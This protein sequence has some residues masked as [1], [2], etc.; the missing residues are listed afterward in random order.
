[1][2]MLRRNLLMLVFLICTVVVADAQVARWAPNLKPEFDRITVNNVGL[3]EVEKNKK[4]GLYSRDW[5]EIVPIEYDSIRPFREG[6]AAMYKAGHFVA[7]T[8]TIGNIIDVSNY[9]YS[10]VEGAEDFSCGALL[11]KRY[12]QS[13][14]WLYHYI[15]YDGRSITPDQYLI[16]A[17]P[18][19]NGYAVVSRYVEGNTTRYYDIIDTNGRS[20]FAGNDNMN[21]VD[22]QFASTFVDGEAIV[23]YK[24]RVHKITTE[25]LVPDQI[26]VYS[27]EGKKN[28]YKV[29]ISDFE[30]SRQYLI[31]GRIHIAAKNGDFMFDKFRRLEEYRL[32]DA[33]AVTMPVPQPQTPVEDKSVFEVTSEGGLDGLNYMGE[34]LLPPQFDKVTYV[35]NNF[36]IVRQKGKY[37]VITADGDADFHF[38]LNSGKDIDFRHNTHD[39]EL[40]VDV[41]VFVDQDKAHVAS[42]SNDCRIFYN[43]AM[44]SAGVRSNYITFNKC[45][46]TIPSDITGAPRDH[47]YNFRVEYDGLVSR[48]YDVSAK[49]WYVMY[50]NVTPDVLQYSLETPDDAITVDFHISKTEDARFDTQ[51]Y[52]KEVLVYQ[53]AEIDGE[54]KE[55]RIDCTKFSETHYQFAIARVESERQGFLIHVREEGCPT[56]EY[57]F[58]LNFNIPEP[59]VVEEGETAPVVDPQPTTVT[60]NPEKQR[61]RPTPPT[62]GLDISSEGASTAGI[63]HA[64]TTVSAGK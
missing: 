9:Q 47:H 32:G 19:S 35:G 60:I 4:V 1:M 28:K 55:V 5:K 41:P 43:G 34:E 58:E 62:L 14:G 49:E 38:T 30:G 61:V 39:V 37:G 59:P 53:L 50:Y 51:S 11:V 7:F 22:I 33:P 63:R 54:V 17:Y 26:Y 25:N 64:Q 2:L 27:P 12:Q 46:L 13:F 45:M 23:I 31:D 42:L 36:V 57:P 44:R 18:F 52:P 16:E 10:L 21:N 56:Y 24:N 40:M 8:D 6:R 3:L 15:N 20:A 29:T 48:T